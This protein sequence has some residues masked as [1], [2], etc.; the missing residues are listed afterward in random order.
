MQPGNILDNECYVACNASSRVREM[1]VH[2]EKMH[3]LRREL[4]S[5]ARPESPGLIH[6]DE[7]ARLND[8]SNVGIGLAR[9]KV[10]LTNAFVIDNDNRPQRSAP[11]LANRRFDIGMDS[12]FVDA[13]DVRYNTSASVYCR[14][15]D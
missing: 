10:R 13:V 12:I 1:P 9:E 6:Y 14:N 7:I 5:I 2:A 4:S 3:V 8:R 11:F 15:D